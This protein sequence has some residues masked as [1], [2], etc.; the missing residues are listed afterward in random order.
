[1]RLL[2]LLYSTLSRR[3]RIGFCHHAW[4]DTGRK[5]PDVKGQFLRFRLANGLI[6]CGEAV[7]QVVGFSGLLQLKAWLDK[8]ANTTV[9]T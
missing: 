5:G 9:T 6:L 8:A 2:L 1:M 4:S 7:D 3:M